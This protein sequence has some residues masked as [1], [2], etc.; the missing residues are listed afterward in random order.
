MKCDDALA[1]QH[2]AHCAEVA[3]FGL[4]GSVRLFSDRVVEHIAKKSAA[5]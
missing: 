1:P 3:A 2:F 5:A 4:Q